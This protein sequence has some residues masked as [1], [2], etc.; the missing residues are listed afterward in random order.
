M[1]ERQIYFT[2]IFIRIVWQSNMHRS[3]HS[4]SELKC[5]NRFVYNE[6]SYYFFQNLSSNFPDIFNYYL[7]ILNLIYQFFKILF[8]KLPKLLYTVPEDV[9]G[10]K[11]AKTLLSRMVVLNSSAQIHLLPHLLI[12]RTGF[13]RHNYIFIFIF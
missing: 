4:L 6:F 8:R 11:L 12:P 2:D 3:L 1:F 9:V 13:L 5:L 7:K 10:S